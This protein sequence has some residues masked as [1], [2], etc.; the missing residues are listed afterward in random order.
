MKRW[1][2][3]ARRLAVGVYICSARRDN[4]NRYSCTG[5]C[6]A[7]P[8]SATPLLRGSLC[9]CRRYAGPQAL[10]VSAGYGVG[11]GHPDGADGVQL[12]GVEQ[13][14]GFEGIGRGP[15]AKAMLSDDGGP[16]LH[17]G[18]R[19]PGQ[20]LAGARGAGLGVR[21]ATG[22]LV[23]AANVVEQGGRLQQLHVGALFAADALGQVPHP[24]H[25]VEPV[26]RVVVVVVLAGRLDIDH[27]GPPIVWRRGAGGWSRNT[28]CRLHQD[29][30]G[31]LGHGVGPEGQ[32]IELES[33]SSPSKSQ[34][35]ALKKICGNG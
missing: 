28:G 14:A 13:D 1:R 8:R 2:S 33:V 25:V 35:P 9:V 23:G 18:G 21:D 20:N 30:H 17:A 29:G 11:A 31:E 12:V 3:A 24:Q 15:G 7:E 10:P 22:L 16:G 19:L 27:P 32:G 26:S 4:L 5:V 34:L 6:S